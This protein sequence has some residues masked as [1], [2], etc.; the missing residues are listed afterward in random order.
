MSRV[1]VV[2][3]GP[4]GLATGILFAREGHQVTV[5]E[6][7]ASPPPATGLDAW[8]SWERGGV[9]QFRQ[10][11]L[12]HARLRHL[13]DAEFPE[14][15]D[16]LERSGGRRF[17]LVSALP[18]TVE[19]R[20]PR[21]G[22]ER[23]ETISARRP[24]LEAAF[25]RIAADSDGIRIRRGVSVEGP[26]VD[27]STPN[28]IPRVVGV[29]TQDGETVPA[30][31]TVDAMGRRSRFGDWVEAIGGRKPYEEVSETG[32]AYYTRHYRSRDGSV[33]EFKGLIFTLLSSLLILTFPT[34]NDTWAIA[35]VCMA[36]D[37]PLKS[38]RRNQ[39]WERVVRAVPHLTHWLDGEPIQDVLAMAGA[40]DRY[41]R[42]VLEGQP[43]V[44]GMIAV[45]DSWACTNPTAGRGVS[46]GVGHAIALR[47]VAREHFDN[48]VR[49][50]ERFHAVTE[51][52][53]TPWYQQQMERDRDRVATIR[54][55]IAG[56]EPQA[57]SA[58]DP[59]ARRQ[60]AFMTA[61][62]YDAEVARAFL[63]VLSCHA[64]PAEIMARPGMV[65]KVMAASAGREP[66]GPPHPTRAE[67]LELLGSA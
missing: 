40:M 38:V 58:T 24:V 55:V 35:V 33:P 10:V 32:F 61:A 4:V 28:G 7:D 19:D 50:A 29:R 42:F 60:A 20:S 30:E 36:G 1:T 48:P 47:D 15:R 43:V 64:L 13:L 3:G 14:V 27:G 25:A 2:G 23:F 8:D 52:T 17:N 6:K 21:P 11:H 54:A 46:L 44:S 63:E 51:E 62:S 12:M 5:L 16:E 37:A 31:L 56:K 49:L 66:L 57:P 65:E 59:A 22:D 18:A 9:A 41:R 45:G 39:A 53:F 67:V 26:V 34:D